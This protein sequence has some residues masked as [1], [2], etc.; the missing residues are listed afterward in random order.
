MVN[1]TKHEAG[2][3]KIEAEVSSTLLIA[4]IGLGSSF[5]CGISEAISVISANP[6]PTTNHNHIPSS[7]FHRTTTTAK[8]SPEVQSL[9][10]DQFKKKMI[11][12][13]SKLSPINMIKYSLEYTLA[14]ST[15][16]QRYT[17]AIKI[18]ST[19]TNKTT[20]SHNNNPTY[21]QFKNFGNIRMFIAF[22]GIGI[23]VLNTSLAYKKGID[24]FESSVLAGT[25]P[26]KVIINPNYPSLPIVKL[27]L[28]NAE[29]T[30]ELILS[31]RHHQ[32]NQRES[33]Q[34][35]KYNSIPVLLSNCDSN[36][37][38]FALEKD[39]NGNSFGI[40]SYFSYPAASSLLLLGVNDSIKNDPNYRNNKNNKIIY[41]TFII[42][43]KD[44]KCSKSSMDNLHD[45]CLLAS[46]FNSN[47]FG[48]SSKLNYLIFKI[49]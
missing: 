47:G 4:S 8:A 48:K 32:Q 2:V 41:P 17:N 22:T 20:N 24:N 12:F 15:C 28:G 14:P 18:L 11:P 5:L 31:N 37:L 27:R 35:I 45:S 26:T 10:L 43:S 46:S 1:Y 39:K 3:E 33:E 34:N 9:L 13:T 29:A 16:L 40:G 36:Q 21:L 19:I 7:Q 42:E 49:S 30:S 25:A 23:I 44:D 6:I 38:R